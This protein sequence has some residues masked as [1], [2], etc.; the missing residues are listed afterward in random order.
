MGECMMRSTVFALG[1]TVLATIALPHG[2]RATLSLASGHDHH[3]VRGRQRHRCDPRAPSRSTCRTRWASRSCGESRRR[4]RAPCR[5]C[6]R[7]RRSRR[8]YAADHHPTRHTR[9]RPA[10]SRPC[11]MTRSRISRRLPA[12]AASVADR[13]PSGPA[14]PFDAGVRQLRQ[15]Q[16]RQA[17]LRARQQH[18]PYHG[19][20]LKRRT[21]IDV[22]RVAYRSNPA[23]MT[24]LIAGHVPAMIPDFGVALPQ[25]KAQKIRPLAVL[26]RE[27]QHDAAGCADAA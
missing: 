7:A 1:L 22:V 3:A 5:Q 15:G 19:E 12:S 10:C 18:R 24:D 26:T 21:G 9:R 13:G 11:P 14:D 17:H 8:P 25:V 23:A 6:G 2:L 27:A 4:R 20:A 16:S